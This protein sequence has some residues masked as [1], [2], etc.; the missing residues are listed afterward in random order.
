MKTFTMAAIAVAVSGCGGKDKVAAAPDTLTTRERQE[1][2]GTSGLP[3]ARGIIK[4]LDIVDTAA[5]RA[6]AL[7][8]LGR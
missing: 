4:A 8:T 7:D 6:A 2:V 3:G 5:A 1:A